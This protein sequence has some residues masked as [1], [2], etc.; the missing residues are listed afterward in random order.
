MKTSDMQ[1][2]YVTH[3]GRDPQVENLWSEQIESPRFCERPCQRITWP[4]LEED[5]QSQLRI[6][7]AGSD[8]QVGEQVEDTVSRQFLEVCMGVGGW[9]QRDRGY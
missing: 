4:V 6:W 3:R 9:R 5:I 1:D 7:E 2:M 8:E